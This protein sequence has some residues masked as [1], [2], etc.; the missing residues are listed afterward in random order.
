MH[1]VSEIQYFEIIIAS[2]A[3]C[4]WAPPQ[5][6]NPRPIR[7]SR[8]KNSSIGTGL[9]PSNT[10][11]HSNVL[12]IIVGT[13]RFLKNCGSHID[14]SHSRQPLVKGERLV[15]YEVN[16]VMLALGVSVNPGESQ[17]DT[18]LCIAVLADFRA[19]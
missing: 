19:D 7:N 1:C 16:A 5:I 3:A 8:R 12:G 9:S 10:Q 15:R 14:A 6:H 18:T 13:H 4:T 11:H 2:P 17:A